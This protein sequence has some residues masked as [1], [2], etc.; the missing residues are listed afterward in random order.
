MYS[1]GRGF[2]LLRRQGIIA[3]IR[4]MGEKVSFRLRRFSLRLN[5]HC[6]R[7]TGAFYIEVE[8]TIP[9]VQTHQVS[10]DIIVCVHDALN[11]IQGCLE[12][13]C[14]LFDPSL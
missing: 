8:R 14:T 6:A 13:Y 12:S 7:S 9:P 1:V 11:D 2:Q 3:F 10:V 5:R 4:R